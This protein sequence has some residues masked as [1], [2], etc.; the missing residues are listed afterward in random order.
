MKEKLLTGIIPYVD[1]PIV[2]SADKSNYRFTFMTNEPFSLGETAVQIPPQDGFVYGTTHD[3]HRIAIY[4]GET[5]LQIWGTQS[6]N[7]CAYVISKGNVGEQ[8]ISTFDT[9][10]FHGGTLNSVF[11]IRAMDVEHSTKETVVKH[12]DDSIKYSVRT[13]RCEFDVEIRSVVK[14][15][16]GIKGRSINN[17]EVVMVLHF[18]QSQP[19]HAFFEHY[20]RIKDMLSFLCFRENVGFDAITI[21]N[22]DSA[23]SPAHTTAAVH[24]YN[25][26]VLTQ[27]DVFNNI[28]FEDISDILPKLTSIFY[29]KE[30]E[31]GDY[32]ILGFMPEN[33]DDAFRMNNQKIRNICSALECELSYVTDIKVDENQ[34]LLKLIDSTK[35]HIKEFRANHEGLDADTYSKIFS[36]MSHWS[37]PLAEQLCALYQK[38]ANEINSLNFSKYVIVDADIKKFVKYRNTITHGRH[39]ILTERVAVTAH[40]LCGLIY[41]CV[42]TRAGLSHE[43]LAEVCKKRMLG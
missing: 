36:S 13:D 8:N 38:Y 14:E 42:L 35:A 20:N 39:Q 6:L 26:T 12:T 5:S 40:L 10:T 43:N 7:T 3:N 34:L 18:K 1:K 41:C 30:N 23:K 32:I 19:L 9:L 27:K 31:K 11:H 22:N 2:F 37:F 25:K 15:R 29:A 28:C 33:D 17:D 24:I 16:F 21:S 4:V